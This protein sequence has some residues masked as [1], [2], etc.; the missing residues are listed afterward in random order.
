MLGA[1]GDAF[2]FDMNTWHGAATN[3]SA[4]ERRL[5]FLSYSYIWTVAQDPIRPTEA[6]M[7]GASPLRRQLFRALFPRPVDT[8]I[9]TDDMLPLKAYWRGGEI[10]RIYA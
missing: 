4:I 1:P 3:T 5:L 10:S 2:I 9:P 7:A 6:V 8:W